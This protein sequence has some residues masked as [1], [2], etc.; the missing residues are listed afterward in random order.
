[1]HQSALL[2]AEVA[3]ETAPQQVLRSLMSVQGWFR[4]TT[5]QVAP[6]HSGPVLGLLVLLDRC[7]PLRA[8][9]LAEIS[10]VDPSVISRQ[11]AQLVDG[12]LVERAADPHD[13]RAQLLSLS[14]E[15]ATLL[16]ATRQAML[17]VVESR[18][19]DWDPDELRAFADQLVRLITDLST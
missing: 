17:A 10:R 2:V 9:E 5:R 3:D 8:R 7:G 11:V 13:G 18:L 1:M 16:A 6:H 15:G 14:A 4:E 19:S 12:G